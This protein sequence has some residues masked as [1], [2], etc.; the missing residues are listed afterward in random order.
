MVGEECINGNLAAASQQRPF[1]QI[2]AQMKLTTMMSLLLAP[3]VAADMQVTPACVAGTT[4][5]AFTVIFFGTWAGEEAFLKNHEDDPTP[6]LLVQQ[7][8]TFNEI[9]TTGN[10]LLSKEE[11]QKWFKEVK[12]VELPDESALIY[13]TPPSSKPAEGSSPKPAQGMVRWVCFVHGKFEN[14]NY[15]FVYLFV[16]NDGA[17]SK[18]VLGRNVA[19]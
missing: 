3:A 15:L 5:G 11:I 14:T 10:G 16:S 19:I 17:V 8:A 13:S 2:P 4:C 7:Q 6:A 12:N 18:P 1:P 9:D